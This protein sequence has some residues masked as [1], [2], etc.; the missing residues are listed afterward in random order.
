LW[1][2][3]FKPAFYFPSGNKASWHHTPGFGAF[4]Q[5]LDPFAKITNSPGKYVKTHHSPKNKEFTIPENLFAS[6]QFEQVN[7]G[8]ETRFV[9]LSFGVEPMGK[10]LTLKSKLNASSGRN[11]ALDN[12]MYYALTREYVFYFRGDAD[13][14]MRLLKFAQQEKI[15]MGKKTSL[16]YGQIASFTPPTKA[17]VDS[18]LTH[19]LPDGSQRATLKSLP[20]QQLLS[21][22]QQNQQKNQELLGCK[23]FRLVNAL[24]TVG[25]YYPP[26]WRKENQTHILLYGSILLER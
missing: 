18:A 25:A 21:Q 14:V 7:L 6:D 16:G 11:K 24:E 1:H 20:Y 19:P 22:R 26:Y 5:G 12:R 4:R 23:D 3:L 9:Q 17:S 8:R 10:R 15:G 2:D 13:G